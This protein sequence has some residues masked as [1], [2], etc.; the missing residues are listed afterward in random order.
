[1]A[2]NSPSP[3]AYFRLTLDGREAVASFKELANLNNETDVIKSM[4]VDA[5]GRPF[6][7]NTPGLVKFGDVTLK[8]V[9]DDQ[10]KL[11]EWR[12]QVIQEG[13]QN[14]RCDAIIESVD[15]TG[16]KIAAFKL[17]NAWPKKY[18]AS[19][20]DAAQ[21]AAALETLVLAIDQ[22]ERIP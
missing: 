2:Q 10:M 11:W 16:K 17:G 9:A 4:S 7:I 20:M 22:F 6:Q 8:R 3:T 18:E 13:V 14:A 5:Q 15:H 1:M 19:S 21:N 12:Q